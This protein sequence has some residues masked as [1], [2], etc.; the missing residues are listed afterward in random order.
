MK[1]EF[2]Q[3]Q[4]RVYDF[5]HF[6]RL[7]H[8]RRQNETIEQ[9]NDLFREVA[10]EDYLAFAEDME[11]KLSPYRKTITNYYHDDIFADFDFIQVLA[12]AVPIDRHEDER[13]YLNDL[14]SMDARTLKQR[15]KKA[16]KEIDR[17]AMKTGRSE[18]TDKEDEGDN[19]FV[20]FIHGL[21]IDPGLKWNLLMMIQNTTKYVSDYVLF[22]RKMLP[23]FLS[24]Y[25]TRGRDIGSVGERLAERLN[26]NSAT[27]LSEITHD[28]VDESIISHDDVVLYVSAIFPHSMRIFEPG[29]HSAI[30]WGKKME[31]SF[32]S[33]ARHHRD[34]RNRRVKVFRS[35][36]DK[37]RYEV[38]RLLAGGMTSTKD[39]AAELGVSSATVSYHLNEFLTTG[40]ISLGK[41]GRKSGYR[42]DYEVLRGVLDGLLDDLNPDRT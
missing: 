16:I 7:L 21:A 42:I 13:S 28:A 37:T 8:V 30:V 31:E 26:R 18:E 39:I 6:P 2:R 33:I 32:A 4:S 25:E 38:L 22:M 14:L 12:L 34:K 23:L 9:S 15:F 5:L 35:L 41:N 3:R 36:G 11:K 27:S 20:S 24:V 40:V 19:A 10:T 29:G 17:D 1:Y